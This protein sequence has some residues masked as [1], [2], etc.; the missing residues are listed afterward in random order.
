VVENHDRSRL[1]DRV[2]GDVRKAR[3]F[4]TILLTLRGVPT[5]YQGQELAQSNTYIPLRRAQDPVVRTHLP[6]LPEAVNRRLPERLNRDEVRTPMQ[7]DAG[8]TAGFC[9]EGVTPWLPVN[10]DRATANVADQ[11]DDP[12]SV[13]SL[14]R[15]L[16]AVRAEHPALHSGRLDLV[17]GAPEGTVAWLRTHGDEQVLVVANLG[18]RIATV[19]T[20]SESAE[21]LV[22]TSPDVALTVLDAT[23]APA[24]RLGAHSAAVLQLG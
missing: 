15:R 4:A 12:G 2:G 9:P 19:P 10:D 22:A 5:I 14:Y 16:F 8:P 3:V 1:L 11:R 24:V 23:R 20:G 17:P 21:V 13:M 7:W 18:D 6:W